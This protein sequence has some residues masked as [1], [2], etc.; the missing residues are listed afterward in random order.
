MQQGCPGA[1]HPLTAGVTW[2]TASRARSLHA[3]GFVQIEEPTVNDF[4]LAMT[5]A[6]LAHRAGMEF[7]GTG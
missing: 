5:A 7:A 6:C 4:S 1:A 2:I 3:A